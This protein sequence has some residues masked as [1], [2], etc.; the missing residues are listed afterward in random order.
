MSHTDVLMFAVQNH[1]SYKPPL[2]HSIILFHYADHCNFDIC[3]QL[4]WD[5]IL[6]KKQQKMNYNKYNYFK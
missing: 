1:W 6:K 3:L 5:L 2:I 4:E